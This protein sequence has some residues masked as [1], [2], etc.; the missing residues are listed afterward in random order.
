MEQLQSIWSGQAWERFPIVQ[1]KSE[2]KAVSKN[3]AIS[4]EEGRLPPSSNPSPPPTNSPHDF[5]INPKS[6]KLW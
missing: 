2:M 4:Q 5:K 1:W 6:G 3:I